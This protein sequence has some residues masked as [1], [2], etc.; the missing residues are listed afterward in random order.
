MTIPGGFAN[1]VA[2]FVFLFN[3]F[4]FDNGRG[5]ADK[6]ILFRQAKKLY[7][8]HNLTDEEA[9]LIEPAACA[10]HGIDKLAVPMGADALVLGAGP[11]GVLFH[12]KIQRFNNV[13]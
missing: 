3:S 9:T 7:R 11:T 12:Q 13:C 10:V 4:W 6:L 1:F 2:V 5:Y 8:I